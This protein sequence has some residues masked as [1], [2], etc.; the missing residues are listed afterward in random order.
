MKFERNRLTDETV[1]SKVNRQAWAIL[2]TILINVHQKKHI[3]KLGR[4]FGESNPYM[5]FGRNWAIN[6]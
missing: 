2:A 3:F 5:K 1:S 4:E 6:E